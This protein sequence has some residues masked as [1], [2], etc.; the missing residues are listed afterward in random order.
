MRQPVAA[1]R[2]R[3]GANNAMQARPP[4]KARLACIEA[5]TLGTIATC[6]SYYLDYC[7]SEHARGHD[8]LLVVLCGFLCGWLLRHDE[9]KPRLW[10][11][12]W[13]TGRNLKASRVQQAVDLERAHLAAMARVDEHVQTEARRDQG[14]KRIAGA[15]F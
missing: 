10:N 6:F 12:V 3:L 7:S 8:L 13:R 11:R 14:A 4:K 9:A 15:G 1:T 2:A 5:R